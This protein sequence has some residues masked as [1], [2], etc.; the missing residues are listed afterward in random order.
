MDVDQLEQFAEALS[1]R[2]FSMK[3]V[4]RFEE[5][6]DEPATEARALLDQ[7]SEELVL[8]D[9]IIERLKTARGLDEDL[10]TLAQLNMRLRVDIELDDDGRTS[11]L[12]HV[13]P[14][15]IP[16]DRAIKLDHS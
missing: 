13:H 1:L 16:L 14:N 11:W 15:G 10:R 8:K 5:L 4:L 6:L 2:D 12:S 7:L 3:E 9:R